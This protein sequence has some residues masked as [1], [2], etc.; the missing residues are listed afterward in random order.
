MCEASRCQQQ[1][2]SYCLEAWGNTER[3]ISGPGTLWKLWAWGACP[4]LPR[5]R[6]GCTWWDTVTKA[7][8]EPRRDTRNS[9]SHSHPMGVSMGWS[10]PADSQ[11]IRET[12]ASFP[13][14][15][16]GQRTDMEGEP[17]YKEPCMCIRAIFKISIEDLL[18]MYQALF[19][20]SKYF[21][22]IASVNKL[23]P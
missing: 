10:K 6:L 5:G 18:C 19:H 3:M 23:I 20:C 22:Y 11:S 8:K 15:R 14:I 21:P 17:Q 2:K 16:E 9:P 7:E 4:H 12:W 1:K 13:G